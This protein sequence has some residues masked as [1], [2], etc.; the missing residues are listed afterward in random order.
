[1]P[2]SRPGPWDYYRRPAAR[3]RE[4]QTLAGWLGL[5]RVQVHGSGALAR[6]VAGPGEDD[7]VTAGGARR[8]ATC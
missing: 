7:G 1:V 3:T 4:L 5:G 2:F 8:P 6:A